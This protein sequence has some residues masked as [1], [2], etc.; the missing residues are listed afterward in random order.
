MATKTSCRYQG[1]IVVSF[2]GQHSPLILS[3]W[4]TVE[5]LP[6]H[7]TRAASGMVREAVVIKVCDYRFHVSLLIHV[8]VKECISVRIFGHLGAMTIYRMNHLM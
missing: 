5:W 7:Q 6:T 3:G 1:I 2:L 4:K 8:S